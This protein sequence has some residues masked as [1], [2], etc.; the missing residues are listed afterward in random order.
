MLWLGHR[1]SLCSTL[2]VICR[3]SHTCLSF[4]MW[5]I[6]RGVSWCFGIAQVNP[7]ARGRA[8]LCVHDGRGLE[9]WRRWPGRPGSGDKLHSLYSTWHRRRCP[10]G[11]LGVRPKPRLQGKRHLPGVWQA[12][13]WPAIAPPC[14]CSDPDPRPSA[15]GAPRAAA[16]AAASA[17]AA[18]F[19]LRPPPAFG[20]RRAR[21]RV[22][23]PTIPSAIMHSLFRKRNKGKYSPTVQTRR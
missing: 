5:V 12:S 7:P 15:H 17:S 14:S 4:H 1:Q 9:A 10:A 6:T 21:R 11:I 23:D 22:P 3:V 18:A 2:S 20:A 19:H 13:K 16:A 8:R